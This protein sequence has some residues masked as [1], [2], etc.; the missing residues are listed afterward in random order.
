MVV[1]VFRDDDVAE[2]HSQ[3]GIGAGANLQP[4]FGT[5]GLPCQSRVNDD[6]LRPHRVHIDDGMT[7]ESVR[8]GLKG[9]F[10]PNHNNFGLTPTGILIARRVLRSIIE[11]RIRCAQNIRRACHARPVARPTGLHVHNVWAVEYAA[12]H[13]WSP[14]AR[15]APGSHK[16]RN[17]V[18]PV[19]LGAAAH[20]FLNEIVCF[21]PANLLPRFIIS[22]I[23]ARALQGMQDAI[24]AVYV[25]G[26]RQHSN[27]HRALRDGLLRVAL[28]LLEN[29]VLDVQ[30]HAST[31]R[32]IPGRRPGV[33]SRDS[34]IPLLPRHRCGESTKCHFYLTSSSLSLA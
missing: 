6:E 32:M 26:Q 30:E 2:C 13:G 18:R 15:F 22:P 17:R 33:C 29:T 23:D 7:P 14:V 1:K 11:F 9:L 31:G 16:G 12:G 19:K 27:R 24:R 10:T 5:R 25:F 21:V 4:D 34:V 3:S 28:D 20:V 8:I